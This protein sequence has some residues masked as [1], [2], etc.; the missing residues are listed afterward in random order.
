M[1]RKAHLRPELQPT[2]LHPRL[3]RALI[4]LTGIRKGILLEP[5]C[6]AGGIL[7]EAGLMGIK[8]VGY[9]ID[10][11]VLKKCKINLNFYT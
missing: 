10:K 1:E 2:S 6:G 4:N 11:I 9:D 7:L 3:A 5:F 8:T